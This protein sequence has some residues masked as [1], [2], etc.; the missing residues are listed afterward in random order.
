MINKILKV[1]KIGGNV[2]SDNEKLDTF[3]SD[4]AAIEEPKILVHGGGKIATELAAKLGVKAK[5]IDGRRITDAQNL[6]IITMVYGG[7]VNKNIVARLQ[8]S[9][10]NALGLSGADANIVK[11]HKRI[12]SHIDYGFAGDIDEVDHYIL[13]TFLNSGITLVICP[14]THDKKGQLLNTNADTMASEIAIALSKTFETHLY[15]CFEKKGVLR[16]VQEE[17]SVIE[18][19]D[20]EIYRQL[21]NE[22]IVADGMLPKLE[23]CF[24]A[25]ENNVEKVFLGDEKMIIQNNPFATQVSL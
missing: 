9:N 24:H 21:R 18:Y 2:I 11:A 12:V 10:C 4:F 23:N 17:N 5:M 13:E 19:I 7:L 22:G 14:I 1:V 16:N 6:D 8:N 15:Y 3:L 25:L 20:K